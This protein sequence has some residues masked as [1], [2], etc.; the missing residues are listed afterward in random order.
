MFRTG[1]QINM[2]PILDRIHDR[3]GRKSSN[4]RAFEISRALLLI[5]F[6]NTMAVHRSGTPRMPSKASFSPDL[7]FTPVRSTFG[8][9]RARQGER[10]PNMTVRDSQIG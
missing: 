6:S 5:L 4:A 8:L 2:E 7:E 9:E 3:V 1:C 10:A